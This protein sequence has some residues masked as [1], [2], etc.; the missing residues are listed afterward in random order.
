MYA[1]MCTEMYGSGISL[2]VLCVTR[3]VLHAWGGT[4]RRPVQWPKSPCIIVIRTRL[5]EISEPS[6]LLIPRLKIYAHG[7]SGT[8]SSSRPETPRG[9]RRAARAHDQSEKEDE[10]ENGRSESEPDVK[11][12]TRT[13][14]VT[15]S[16]VVLST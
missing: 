9:A 13:T 1:H 11:P 8:T 14:S 4:R 6:R 10:L 3:C 16:Q 7:L 2:V 12:Q 15:Q 5:I